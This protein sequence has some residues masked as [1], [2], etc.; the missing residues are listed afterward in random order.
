MSSSSSIGRD[1][2]DVENWALTSSSSTPS[3]AMSRANDGE[4]AGKV[5]VGGFSKPLSIIWM[6]FDAMQKQYSSE[7]GETCK[8]I[9]DTVNSLLKQLI[10]ADPDK[11][12]EKWMKDFKEKVA[13][14]KELCAFSQGKSK[15]IERGWEAQ[16]KAAHSTADKALQV[17]GN[18]TEKA[19]SLQE[20]QIALRVTEGKNFLELK[21]GH[22]KLE[23][24]NMALANAEIAKKKVL[25]QDALKAAREVY[26]TEVAIAN[27]S[28][29]KLQEQGANYSLELKDPFLDEDG[30]VVNGEVKLKSKQNDSLFKSV[31]GVDLGSPEIVRLLQ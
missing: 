20:K 29:E 1:K 11:V 3:N 15:T 30:H 26:K 27:K 28:L 7:I 17:L 5:V 16:R 12:G 13:L 6:G 2:M 23:Q 22:Y 19:L 25:E 24:A 21:D 9:N 14:A 8:T 31:F 10:A 18:L 4:E